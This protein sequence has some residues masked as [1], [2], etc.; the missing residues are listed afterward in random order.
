MNKP[1]N[2]QIQLHWLTLIIIIIAYASIELRGFFPKSSTA[3][4]LM[5]ETHYNSGVLVW[6]IMFI[7]LSFQCKNT[8]PRHLHALKW[9]AI[10]FTSMNFLLYFIFIALP[11]SGIVI[12]FM[13]GKDWSL[14][15]INIP[16]VFTSSRE[17]KS[18]IKDTHEVMANIGYGLIAI[19]AA[20]ALYFHYIRKKYKVS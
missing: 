9:K 12:M 15:G 17:F 5:K 6:I 4:T 11:V 14:F 18:A 7:R 1:S 13:S 19:H 16:Q 2:L 3:Y 20:T 8:K 10:Y